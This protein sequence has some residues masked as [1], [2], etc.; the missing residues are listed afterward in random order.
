MTTETCSSDKCSSLDRKEIKRSNLTERTN[1]SI[2]YQQKLENN[3][4]LLSA[5]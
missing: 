5:I 4:K 3:K 1:M 2:S